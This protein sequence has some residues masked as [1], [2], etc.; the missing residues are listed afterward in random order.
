MYCISP[1]T[2][3]A[4][5]EHGEIRLL[6]LIVNIICNC[7]VCRLV[8]SQHF[9]NEAFSLAVPAVHI[10]QLT[11]WSFNLR[12]ALSNLWGI[13]STVRLYRIFFSSWFQ[14]IAYTGYSWRD[15]HWK[16]CDKTHTH[17]QGGKHLPPLLCAFFFP[18]FQDATMWAA[19]G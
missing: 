15:M 8:L 18:S 3:T 1:C 9:T 16:M 7:N 5:S 2:W 13:G 12:F 6:L 10:L 17:A 4:W 19:K 14:N 11:T